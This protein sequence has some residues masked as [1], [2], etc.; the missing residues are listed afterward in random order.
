MV[1]SNDDTQL[2]GITNESQCSMQLKVS[3]NKLRIPF[4][5]E[6]DHTDLLI[7]FLSQILPETAR[8][9]Y[10]DKISSYNIEG[11]Y[12]RVWMVVSP[13]DALHENGRVDFWFLPETVN[14]LELGK[15]V[16]NLIQH[17]GDQSSFYIPNNLFTSLQKR[18]YKNLFDEP[19]LLSFDNLKQCLQSFFSAV[20]EL[21]YERGFELIDKAVAKKKP[22]KYKALHTGSIFF[23]P[24][25]TEE[26]V[27]S[28]EDT[29][30]CI[31]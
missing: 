6:K 14:E 3:L 30:S 24:N 8:V 18:E 17:L 23:L 29:P 31:F 25:D 13:E 15:I 5:T 22:S 16:Q 4:N 2:G 12:G 1:L 10:T 20:E 28:A 7:T 19:L 21:A 9:P 27:I 26:E 11:D